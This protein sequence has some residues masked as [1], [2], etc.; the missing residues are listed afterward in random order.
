MPQQDA[1]LTL[2]DVTDK[3]TENDTPLSWDCHYLV[4]KRVLSGG[5]R[6]FAKAHNLREGYVVTFH[7]VAPGRLLVSYFSNQQQVQIATKFVTRKL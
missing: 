1:I 3:A 7:L 5:W 2:T 4:A 6:R